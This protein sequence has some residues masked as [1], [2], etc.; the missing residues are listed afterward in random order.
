LEYLEGEEKEA[1]EKLYNQVKDKLQIVKVIL[2]GSKALGTHQLYSDINLLL[3]SN[4]QIENEDRDK[5][6]EVTSDLNI[7]YGIALACLFL[8][9][10]D[11]KVGKVNLSLKQRIEQEGVTIYER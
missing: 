6:S 3:L 4:K 1:I 7:E 11:W 10:L 9:V 2:F 8:N 5:M